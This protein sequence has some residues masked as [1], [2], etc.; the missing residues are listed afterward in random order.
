MKMTVFE[1]VEVEEFSLVNRFIQ[2]PYTTNS[3]ANTNTDTDTNTNTSMLPGCG[4]WS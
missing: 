4:S 1:C 3:N 2:E